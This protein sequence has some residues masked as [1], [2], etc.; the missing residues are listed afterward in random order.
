MG[1]DEW[2]TRDILGDELGVGSQRTLTIRPEG[3][4]SSHKYGEPVELLHIETTW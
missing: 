1:G 4:G 2:L 3:L